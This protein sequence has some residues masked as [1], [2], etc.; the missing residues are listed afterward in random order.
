MLDSMTTLFCVVNRSN[1]EVFRPRNVRRQ[2]VRYEEVCT[3]GAEILPVRRTQIDFIGKMP[4]H[5]GNAPACGAM[6]VRTVSPA[7]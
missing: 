2:T 7:C 5:I 4:L 3:G 1:T 6:D